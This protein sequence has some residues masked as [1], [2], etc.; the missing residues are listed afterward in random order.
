MKDSAIESRQ[1]YLAVDCRS[2]DARAMSQACRALAVECLEKQINRVLIDAIECDPEG[3]Y[4]L[5][6]AFTMMILAGIPDRFRLALLTDV[7]HVRVL[8]A[9]LQRDLRLLNIEARLFGRENEAVEWLL[10][11][12]AGRAAETQRRAEQAA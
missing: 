1:G 7:P 8:F 5:R 6:D 12:S 10:P 4:A 2:A 3:H 9:D 11:A